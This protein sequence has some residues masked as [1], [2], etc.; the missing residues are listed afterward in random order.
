MFLLALIATCVLPFIVGPWAFVVALLLWVAAGLEYR[1]EV[2]RER[3]RLDRLDAQRWLTAQR[4][5]DHHT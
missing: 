1:A 5:R 4:R 2:A 3:R